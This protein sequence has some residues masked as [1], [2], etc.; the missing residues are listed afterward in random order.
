VD[1][2]FLCFFIGCS[3]VD[4]NFLFLFIGGLNC[5]YELPLF[6]HGGWGRGLNSVHELPVFLFMYDIISSM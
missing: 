1:M 5:G 3:T 4:M 2:N 6:A